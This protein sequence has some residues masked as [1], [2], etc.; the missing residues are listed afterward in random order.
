MTPAGCW[1]G[2]STNE[3]HSRIRQLVGT[4]M[5]RRRERIKNGSIIVRF[6]MAPMAVNRLITKGWLMPENRRN[7]IAVTTALRE[8]GARML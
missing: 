6:E 1:L 8:F 3:P 2:N 5:R 7:P 4:R